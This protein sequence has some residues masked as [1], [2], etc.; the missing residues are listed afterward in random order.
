MYLKLGNMFAWVLRGSRNE[1]TVMIG[2]GGRLSGFQW[3][4]MIQC[5]TFRVVIGEIW[6]AQR[7][8]V[9]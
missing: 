5:R 4:E 6:E 7:Y 9:S 3:H 2:R 8:Y 1:A